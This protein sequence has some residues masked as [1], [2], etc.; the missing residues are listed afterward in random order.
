ME[1]KSLYTLDKIYGLR[2]NPADTR[3]AALNRLSDNQTD[4]VNKSDTLEISG[5]VRKIQ[6]I[7]S[8]VEEGTYNNME[9]D[10]EVALRLLQYEEI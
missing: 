9:I 4:K 10:K 8:R 5:D 2:N 3:K 6:L 7:K 1:I